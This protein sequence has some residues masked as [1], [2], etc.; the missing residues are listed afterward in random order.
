M[1]NKIFKYI[2][3]VVMSV[4]I[5]TSMGSIYASASSN[6]TDH[7]TQSSKENILIS[8]PATFSTSPNLKFS[9][10]KPGES[11]TGNV[12]DS[13][14]GRP[15]FGVVQNQGIIEYRLV[16]ESGK[17]IYSRTINGYANPIYTP[18]SVPVPAGN[19]RLQVINKGK[20]NVNG[21]AYV[22]IN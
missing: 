11:K 7:L 21:N 22:Y 17:I 14:Y 10:L 2:I 19:Y 8:S 9:T 13:G 1:K 6:Q 15:N 20:V 16:T 5:F 18:K 4:G 12:F 3:P